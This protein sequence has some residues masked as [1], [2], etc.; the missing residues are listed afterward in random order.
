M[1]E[2]TPAGELLVQSWLGP[3]GG[4]GGAAGEA[5]GVVEGVLFATAGGNDPEELVA[6]FDRL[7]A[8]VDHSLDLY[9]VCVVWAG[10]ECWNVAV[11]VQLRCDV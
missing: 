7:A 6:S 9:K 2:A 8:W 3:R 10:A 5:D 1:K 11:A 4:G